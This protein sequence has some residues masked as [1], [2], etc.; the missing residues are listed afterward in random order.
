RGNKKE[1]L[2][3]AANLL[4]KVGLSERVLHKPGELSGG[5]RQRAA[6]ARALVT[7]PA[8]ILADEPT[9]N[10]DEKTADQVFD[11]ILELNQSLGTSL[12][13][14]THNMELSRRVDRVLELKEG[15]LQAS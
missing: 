7:E 10:L 4:E 8:C 12:I 9:G 14:V 5:E 6:I 3:K 1:A 15:I 13:M 11:L 2:E